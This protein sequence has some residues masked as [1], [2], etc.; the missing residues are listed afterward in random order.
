MKK[1]KSAKTGTK[2]TKKE[3]KPTARSAK[4]FPALEKKMNLQSRQA[5]I[6]YDYLSQLTDEEKTWLNK[7]TEEYVNA[8]FDKNKRKRLHKT[9]AQVKD[10]Y[11]RNNSRNRDILTK[12]IMLNRVVGLD[13]VHPE[14]TTNSEDLPE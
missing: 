1:S 10:C 14:N 6:D 2:S 7:F 8:S 5:L 9:K 4:R 13:E 3:R 11:D 12:A